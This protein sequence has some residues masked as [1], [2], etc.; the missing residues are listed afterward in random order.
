MSKAVQELAEVA[1]S[2]RIRVQTY[3]CT[4]PHLGLACVR[5]MKY[6]LESL[7]VMV[8]NGGKPVRSYNGSPRSIWVMCTGEL[9][10]T[11]LGNSTPLQFDPGA[12]SLTQCSLID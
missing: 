6:R 5:S 10:G 9:L 1:A 7:G 8:E 4:L 12:E 3:N 2:D 11:A